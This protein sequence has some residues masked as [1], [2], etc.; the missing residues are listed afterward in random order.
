MNITKL[1]GS[2]PTRYIYIKKNEGGGRLTSCHLCIIDS[3]ILNRSITRIFTFSST[4]S[5]FFCPSATLLFSNNPASTLALNRPLRL[6]NQNM[7]RSI[8]PRGRSWIET[9]RNPAS[10]A[11]SLSASSVKPCCGT[12]SRAA[13]RMVA[14]ELVYSCVG[15][16]G[17]N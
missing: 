1:D 2:E 5:T 3:F 4:E 12:C 6:A 14:W 7:T 11:P 9:S 13:E 15:R 10:R 8:S 16:A 17:W